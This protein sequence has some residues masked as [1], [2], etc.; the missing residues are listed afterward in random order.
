M[1]RLLL[2]PLFLSLAGCA[3]LAPLP[4]DSPLRG[5]AEA[6]L[7][8]LT[9]NSPMRGTAEADSQADPEP[10]LRHVRIDDSCMDEPICAEG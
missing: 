8:P 3:D 1:T 2:L 10:P 9:P 6:D 7:A 5:K 4:E